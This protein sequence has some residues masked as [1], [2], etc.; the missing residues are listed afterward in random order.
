MSRTFP[1]K[2]FIPDIYPD[3]IPTLVFESDQDLLDWVVNN[4]GGYDF[5][6]FMY[7]AIE[8][9]VY[10]SLT[11][12]QICRLVTP[13]AKIAMDISYKNY[14]IALNRLLEL[15]IESEYYELCSEINSLIKLID[16]NKNHFE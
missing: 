6:N 2:F 9:A 8:H 11:Y 13:S 16:E 15:S 5:I 7:T 1:Q 14:N 4:K 12:I 3:Q 10:N